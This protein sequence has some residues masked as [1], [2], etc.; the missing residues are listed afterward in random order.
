MKSLQIHLMLLLFLASSTFATQS[1]SGQSATTPIRSTLPLIKNHINTIEFLRA[2]TQDPERTEG[3]ELNSAAKLIAVQVHLG[4][5]VGARASLN[6][7]FPKRPAKEWETR[8]LS[9]K[10]QHKSTN[11]KHTL[12]FLRHPELANLQGRPTLIATIKFKQLKAALT[13]TPANFGT[14]KSLIAEIGETVPEQAGVA[15][16]AR[17]A[18][19]GALV[20]DGQIRTARQFLDTIVDRKAA[21]DDAIQLIRDVSNESLELLETELADFDNTNIYQIDFLNRKTRFHRSKEQGQQLFACFLQAQELSETFDYERGISNATWL[22][23]QGHGDLANKLLSRTYLEKTSLDQ[24]N[25]LY[26]EIICIR[27]CVEIHDLE[28]AKKHV[29]EFNRQYAG[30]AGT[31]LRVDAGNWIEDQIVTLP[32]ANLIDAQP[33]GVVELIDSIADRSTMLSFTTRFLSHFDEPAKNI[34]CNEL[35]Q[36]AIARLKLGPTRQRA[37]H[38]ASLLRFDLAQEHKDA[39]EEYTKDSWRYINR[40]SAKLIQQITTETSDEGAAA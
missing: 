2:I 18:Y 3:F 8:V 27:H 9:G 14:A 40:Q 1:A 13:Q 15:R 32:L 38:A 17:R 12:Q 19:I 7:F 30:T 10:L 33:N 29:G 11:A 16:L 31:D 28:K 39:L 25:S 5:Q 22:F 20:S 36:T 34:Y 21:T 35:A 23:K 6:Q 37:E 26:L 4:D 24:R